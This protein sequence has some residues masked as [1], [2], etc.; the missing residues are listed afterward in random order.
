MTS[1]TESELTGL[2][3]LSWVD[4]SEKQDIINSY[5]NAISNAMVVDLEFGY[6]AGD[7]ELKNFRIT[8]NPQKNEKNELVGYLGT[9]YELI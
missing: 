3:W 4:E 8:A 9:V 1:R 2:N 7:D 5:K 6:I